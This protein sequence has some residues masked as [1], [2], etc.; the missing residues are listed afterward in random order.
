MSS[1]LSSRAVRLESVD[2]DGLAVMLHAT[3]GSVEC[4]IFYSACTQVEI[5]GVVGVWETPECSYD[6]MELQCQHTF[7]ACALS[8]HFLTNYMTCPLCRH[9]V[10][11]RMS[12]GCVPESIRKVYDRHISP[13]TSSV[14]WLDFEPEMFLRDLR[15]HVDFFPCSVET[16]QELN[17]TT[18]C[19]GV[20]DV[21]YESDTHGIFRTHLSFRR[22][23]NSILR[24]GKSTSCQFSLTHPLIL[25][26][27]SSGDVSCDALDGY[28]CTFLHEIAV[29]CCCMQ[30]DIMTINLQVNLAVL[31]SLCLS[32]VMGYIDTV[33]QSGA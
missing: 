28:N 31:Y 24:S 25:T 10:P 19:V 7:N 16:G 30:H 6:C 17:L 9:G 33:S 12:V 15:L 22:H 27:F 8:L 29:L 20:E 2:Q 13:D 18:P 32:T 3:D 5:D 1:Y 21:D 14:D 26:S 23:F 4:N 11:A